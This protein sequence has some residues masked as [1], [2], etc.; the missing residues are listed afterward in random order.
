MRHKSDVAI[1]DLK[2]LCYWANDMQNRIDILPEQKRDRL[3]ALLNAAENAA[4][5]RN[6]ADWNNFKMQLEAVLLPS[7][8]LST[9]PTLCNLR[10][11]ILALGI[12]WTI[13]ICLRPPVKTIKTTFLIN[14][15]GPHELGEL[16][17]ST[18]HR[19]IWD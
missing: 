8:A 11:V 5:N 12:I 7:T 13:G 16:I 19:W 14:R 6:L 18:G 17:I 15:E 9:R 1:P 10:L 2:E 4:Q 3:Y